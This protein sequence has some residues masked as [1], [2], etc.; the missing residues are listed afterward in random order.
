MGLDLYNEGYQMIELFILLQ[1]YKFWHD[2]NLI[3]FPKD[4]KEVGSCTSI[5]HKSVIFS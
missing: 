3:N 2:S 4:K 5:L 1:L